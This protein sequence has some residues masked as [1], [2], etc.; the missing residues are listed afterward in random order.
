MTSRPDRER[1]PSGDHDPSDVPDA[2][3]RSVTPLSPPPGAYQDIRSRA[4]TRR[5]G[6]FLWT[7]VAVACCAAAGVVVVNATSDHT[8]PPS[9]AVG[10]S[11]DA[12]AQGRSATGSTTPSGKDSSAAGG[13][14]TASSPGTTGHP[15]SADAGPATCETA[16]LKV[17]LGAGEGAA[18]SQYRPLRITNT[19]D[20]AC[21]LYGFP[22]V[23]MV[24][25]AGKQVG[26]PADR[27]GSQ[28]SGRV[29]M[30]PGQRAQVTLRIVNAANYGGDQCHLTDVAGIRVY[31]PGERH[32][33]IVHVSGLQGCT[34]TTAQTLTV[35]SYGV[36]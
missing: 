6:R 26:K 5:R 23:S 16:D 19:G 24:D 12:S 2:L 29:V 3:R 35:T 8:S 33:V 1:R 21:S 20:A 27:S 17:A 31:P 18:G 30:K 4:R 11:D 34:S 28:A 15:K 36:H 22:G 14:A 13:G 25:A 7:G 32:S 10:A 9:V